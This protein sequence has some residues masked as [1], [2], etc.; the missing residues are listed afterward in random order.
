MP[1]GVLTAFLDQSA[2]ESLAQWPSCGRFSG[3]TPCWGGALSS[4]A[5]WTA[6][7]ALDAT[8]YKGMARR[9]ASFFFGLDLFGKTETTHKAHSTTQ[10]HV[11]APPVQ[12][13]QIQQPQWQA[14]P[15]VY[16][17]QQ[18][19]QPPQGQ[20]GPQMQPPPMGQ[21]PQPYQASPG[22]E[23]YPP[24]PV[25][26]T[27]QPMPYYQDHYGYGQGTDSSDGHGNPSQGEEDDDL[28]AVDEPTKG[29]GAV[30]AALI[31]GLT[32]PAGL[33]LSGAAVYFL[34]CKSPT[35]TT[36]FPDDSDP[37]D[38]SDSDDSTR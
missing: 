11:A 33:A 16:P 28:E 2:R 3:G 32:A 12:P 34:F 38:Y 29:E 10:Q 14:P 35:M 31:V 9:P 24:Q 21:Y 17:Q 5:P 18:W 7:L 8:A 22:P 36:D 30:N 15:Q 19:Q 1:S 37:D 4:D 26:P 23:P 27:Q 6:P 13:Q 20:P 25:P